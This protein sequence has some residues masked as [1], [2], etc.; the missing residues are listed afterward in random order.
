MA[1][2]PH[3]QFCNPR[4]SGVIDA[5]NK[6]LDNKISRQSIDS[7]LAVTRARRA[8]QAVDSGNAAA[9]ASEAAGADTDCAVPSGL[10]GRLTPGELLSWPQRVW[11][12]GSATD[13]SD[14]EDF[15]VLPFDSF[16]A[17]RWLDASPDDAEVSCALAATPSIPRPRQHMP[18]STI[19]GQRHLAN[20]VF[21]CRSMG[22]CSARSEQW[23]H[24]TFGQTSRA[25][26]TR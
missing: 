17:C 23:R 7:T 14:D 18:A 26:V 22:T 15:V 13:S 19:Y 24:T 3:M 20:P 11:G 25:S 8:Q 1:C 16:A 12:A 9:E 21:R 2:A 4:Y 5:D 6:I 10:R